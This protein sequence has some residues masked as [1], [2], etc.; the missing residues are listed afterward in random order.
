MFPFIKRTLIGLLASVVNAS[1]H[2]KYVL[3]NN[4]QCMT[5]PNLI[6]LYP[7]EYTLKDEV[8]IHLRLIYIN[9]SEVEII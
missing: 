7:N 1:N 4:Q 6:N 3:F 9:V 8:T 5:Q 2:T